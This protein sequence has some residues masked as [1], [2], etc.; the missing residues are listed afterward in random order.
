KQ[1]TGMLPKSASLSE[2]AKIVTAQLPAQGE[3]DV[4]QIPTYDINV[5]KKFLAGIANLLSMAA[6]QELN[7]SKVLGQ[8][9]SGTYLHGDGHGSALFNMLTSN[10]AE[11][12][13]NY[14][15]LVKSLFG[16]K[17]PTDPTAVQNTIY[18][19]I[20]T[21]KDNYVNGIPKVAQHFAYNPVQVQQQTAE[22]QKVR[23]QEWDQKAKDLAPQYASQFGQAQS[24]AFQ[25][26]SDAARQLSFYQADAARV[27]EFITSLTNIETKTPEETLAFANRVKRDTS[28]LTDRVMWPARILQGFG[29]G[30]EAGQLAGAVKGLSDATDRLVEQAKKSVK[31]MSDIDV[32]RVR[33]TLGRLASIKAQL[34][35]AKKN[36]GI[37]ADQTISAAEKMSNIIKDR[38]GVGNVKY[39]L[40][41]LKEF[42]DYKVYD[43]LDKDTI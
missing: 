39:L 34:E 25:A 40:D 19:N 11:A 38:Y 13:V 29:K 5:V 26:V 36:Y 22:A 14:G 1:P 32:D 18:E 27:A 30:T 9:G 43:D 31:L 8:D 33:A 28:G 16:G 6:S 4:A 17:P 35:E 42:G 41:G 2:I 20:R 3:G 37:D 15:S 24:A 12:V 21:K 7:F 10:R 23:Q